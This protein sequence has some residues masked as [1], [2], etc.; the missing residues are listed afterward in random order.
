MEETRM[1]LNLK[2][3]ILLQV[4]RLGV[5]VSSLE[6]AKQNQG[7]TDRFVDWAENELTKISVNLESAALR[8]ERLEKD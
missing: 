8:A 3:Q 1:E 6:S 4:E 7:I 2:E 5:I